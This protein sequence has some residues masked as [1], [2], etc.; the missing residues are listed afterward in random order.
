MLQCIH[1]ISYRELV[2]M[3]KM[4]NMVS[5]EVQGELF[6]R[7][8]VW[9]YKQNNRTV[10]VPFAISEKQAIQQCAYYYNVIPQ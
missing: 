8:N 5:L 9:Y 2:K 4:V 10:R 6:N 3:M 1:K 7:G